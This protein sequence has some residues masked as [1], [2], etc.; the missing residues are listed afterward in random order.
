MS[1]KVIIANLMKDIIQPLFPILIGLG[2]LLFFW[3]LARY[4]FAMS[5]DS[6]QI[7]PAKE[8]MIWS[9]VTIT[10]MLSVWGLVQLLQ[11]I[12][13]NG[14]AITAPPSIPTFGSGPTPSAPVACTDP[15][16]HPENCIGQ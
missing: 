13:L 6:K 9:V 12:F 7:G 14:S 15:I 11:G 16:N 4:L 5:G 8:Y 1:L 3:G 10:V 2:I